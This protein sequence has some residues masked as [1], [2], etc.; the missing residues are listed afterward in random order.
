MVGSRRGTPPGGIET[1]EDAWKRV[2]VEHRKIVALLT[3]LGEAKG[4]ERI[5]ELANE[6][7]GILPGH[8]SDEEGPRGFFEEI[9]ML[10]P[11]MDRRL[12]RLHQQHGEIVNALD[13]VVAQ[14]EA[15][16]KNPAGIERTRSSL[17][18]MLRAHERIENQLITDFY[19]TD[20]G[21][22]G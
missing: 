22:A 12:R 18:D 5:L 4:P 15:K 7:G 13:A 9:R 11:D 16:T 20:E 1:T 14:V 17:C 2:Q 10:R 3:E 21:G 6:L 19:L 8:F